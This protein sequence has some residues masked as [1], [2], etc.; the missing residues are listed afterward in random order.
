MLR[1]TE[2]LSANGGRMKDA[3]FDA[4]RA[5]FD[6][7]QIVELTVRAAMCEFFNRFNEAFQLDV[8]PVAE[9]LYR[10]AMARRESDREPARRTG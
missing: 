9:A 3:T 6:E 2:R 7:Q 8:E 10:T 5:H 4:L 1:Y